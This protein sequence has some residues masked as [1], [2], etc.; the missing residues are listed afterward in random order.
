MTNT[1]ISSIL[2]V[3]F[4]SV[5]G[6]LGAVFLKIGAER[7]K[8][9][10]RH[11]FNL[12]LAIGCALFLTSSVPYLIAIKHGELSVLFP[13]VSF[14]YVCGLFWSKVFFG[15]PFTKAKFVGLALILVGVVFVG[16]GKQ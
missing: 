7:L 11:L 12:K 2:L 10:I 13:M 3:L 15:E 9:G 14:G 6:S 8:Y 5:I 1:P 16:L 4:G